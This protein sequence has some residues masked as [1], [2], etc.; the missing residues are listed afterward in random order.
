MCRLYDL[1]ELLENNA[2]CVVL[3]VKDNSRMQLICLGCF[4]GNE[5]MF[6]LTKGSN[7]TCT[8]FH[9]NGHT[10]SW[11]WGISGYTLVSDSIK[12]CGIL[13]EQCITNDFGICI[14][15]R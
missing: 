9:T 6:R 8:V 4:N 5:T 10:C 1:V 12:K 15:K 13:I 14:E 3:K 2:E 7:H 11:E